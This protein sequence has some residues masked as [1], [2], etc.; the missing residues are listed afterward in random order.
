[1]SYPRFGD[2]RC[3]L[4]CLEVSQLN[5]YQVFFTTELSPCNPFSIL[6]NEYLKEHTLGNVGCVVWGKLCSV[7]KLL[8]QG[9]GAFL[10]S[11]SVVVGAGLRA[12][13]GR[14]GR[15]EGHPPDRPRG[16]ACSIGQSFSL[17]RGL[18]Q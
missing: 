6:R 15:G 2:A 4:N 1:M 7:W 13:M 17:R 3:A 9:A 12:L 5:V 11:G 8:Y 14:G 18:R 10:S 16:A